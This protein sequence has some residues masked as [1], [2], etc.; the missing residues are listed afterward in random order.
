MPTTRAFL[1]VCSWLLNVFGIFFILAAHEHYS[2][3]VFIAFY[4]CTRLF[5]YYHTLS[6]NRWGCVKFFPARHRCHDQCRAVIFMW[7]TSDDVRSEARSHLVSFVPLLRRKDRGCRAQPL[8]ESVGL[9]YTKPALWLVTAVS[10]SKL[11]RDLRSQERQPPSH[12]ILVIA[13]IW[14]AL[15]PK[16]RTWR[17]CMPARVRF[18][19]PV[20]CRSV[21]EM[22]ILHVPSHVIRG[23]SHLC[24]FF[25]TAFKYI[26][27]YISCYYFVTVIHPVIFLFRQ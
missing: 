18:R 11:G 20:S 23:M 9:V 15:R 4:L 8:R 25:V 12:P 5:L 26:L 13:Q 2:I 17:T 16:R 22:W 14:A 3:D 10:R 27:W 21:S 19:V 6:N 7:Q 1:T 24:H